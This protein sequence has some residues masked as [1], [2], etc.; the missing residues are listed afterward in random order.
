[1]RQPG[2]GFNQDS[3]PVELYKFEM[4][5]QR[6]EFCRGQGLQQMIG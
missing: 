5:T 1:M 4:R 6:L 2:A 3:F